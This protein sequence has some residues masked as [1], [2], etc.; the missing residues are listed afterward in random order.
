M[1]GITKKAKERPS[2]NEGQAGCWLLLKIRFSSCRRRRQDI[3]PGGSWTLG[4][5]SSSTAPYSRFTQE[6]EG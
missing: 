6:G 2:R 3:R 4:A 5:A 1:T